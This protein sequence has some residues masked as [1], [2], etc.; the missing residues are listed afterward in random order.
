MNIHRSYITGYSPF[1]LVYE[2]P[3]IH[4][5]DTA[6]KYESFDVAN[7]ITK[8]AASGTRLSIKTTPQVDW[9]FECYLLNKLINYQVQK[10]QGKHEPYVVCVMRL[11]EYAKL[12][13]NFESDSEA[14]HWFF[15]GRIGT[16]SQACR[17]W[18]IRN[19]T[20]DTELVLLK[21]SDNFCFGS[22]KRSPN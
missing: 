8:Y 17:R 19:A 4:P 2:W 15:I 16:A 12:D 3:P 18:K 21:I 9:T 11:E 13:G 10:L 14:K 20:I 7:D 6:M 22:W 1:K 5:L